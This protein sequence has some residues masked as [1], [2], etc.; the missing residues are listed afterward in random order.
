MR[1]RRMRRA[2]RLLVVLGLAVALAGCGSDNKV[3]NKALLDFKEEAQTRL[4]E[5]TTT[6]APPTTTTTAVAATATTAAVAKQP[7]S[8]TATTSPPT[9]RPATATTATTA[10]TAQVP[11]EAVLA[12]A[13]N[14]DTTSDPPLDPQ[15]ARVYVGGIVRWTNTD[16]K[17]HSVQAVSGQF[18]SPDIPPGGTFEYK[19]TTA[20]IFDYSDGT[21]PYVNATLEVL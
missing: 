1:R 10:T 17:P 19:A 8:G 4:G 9:T 11:Q 15:Y 18:R 14:G 16:S 3:G 13:I 20:G 21:R 2:V 7:A 5:T 6:T 12:I